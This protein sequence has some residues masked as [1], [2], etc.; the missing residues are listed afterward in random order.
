[1]RAAWWFVFW[2]MTK[3]AGETCISVPH[4]NFWGNEP[5]SPRFMPMTPRHIVDKS[6]MQPPS[7][8]AKPPLPEPCTDYLL[9]HYII[10]NKWK[11]A[12]AKSRRHW[13][14]LVRL[15]TLF[16]PCISVATAEHGQIVCAINF[17]RWESVCKR[18]YYSFWGKLSRYIKSSF[19]FICCMLL[20]HW[21]QIYSGCISTTVALRILFSIHISV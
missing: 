4:C 6:S 12:G 5:P 21:S 3:S 9:S 2:N 11:D 8:D 17:N 14:F 15:H 1:M 10:L 19:T 18:I 7:R 16:V 20:D 13:D